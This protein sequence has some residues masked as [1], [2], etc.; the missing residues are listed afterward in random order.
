MTTTTPNISKELFVEILQDKDLVQPDDLLIFQTLYSLDKQEASAT[1]LARIIGWSDK[2]GVVG[3]IVGLGKRILKKHDIKQTEREDGTRKLWDFFF[4]GYYK[5]TFFIYQLKLELKE[6]LEECGLT[7]NIKP[8]SIQNSYLFVWNPNKWSQWIDPNNEP[9]IEKN[10]EEL[11]NTGKVTL[12]WSCRSH[13]SIRPGD[14]A[15]LARVGSTP[16]GIFASGK[17]VSEPFLSQHW[18]GEDKD[19][20]RVLI[21]FD[22]LLNPEKEPILTV[23]NL[24]KG[25]L[26]KQTWT[27]QSSGISIRPEVADELEE[28]CFEFLIT[29]NIRYSPFSETT[30]TTITYIEGS[31]TQVTQTRY[32]RN[33][34]ARKECLKHYGYSCSVCDFN[35]ERFYGSLGYKFI[36]IH[37]LTQ[38]ATIKQEYKVNPIQDLRPVCP[39]CHSMLHKQNPP[40]TIDELKDIIKNG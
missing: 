27:P 22:T 23:E 5:G 17:V 24:D 26:S 7:E 12:M 40:L 28:E 21:E 4:T 25:N 16:R 1:D 2:N 13:K 34:Y 38:V 31:A 11:K 14:R 6:A 32:E 8:I 20:P 29:Q 15:F 35:F 3:K 30:D 10:I 18:S 37:H 36:H 19:V 9:Y 33:I 39:N